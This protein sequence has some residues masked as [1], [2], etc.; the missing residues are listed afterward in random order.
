[1]GDKASVSSL[2]TPAK[3]D[4]SYITPTGPHFYISSEHISNY[5]E[6][7]KTRP[8]RE[9]FAGR[10]YNSILLPPCDEVWSSLKEKQPRC[11]SVIWH[12]HRINFYLL[13]PLSLLGI[14]IITSLVCSYHF[15]TSMPVYKD[16]FPLHIY[17]V[18]CTLVMWQS[19]VNLRCHSSGATTLFFCHSLLLAWIPPIKLGGMASE[20][21]VLSH[22]LHLPRADYRHYHH[23]WFFSWV[24]LI[25]FW[26]SPMYSKHFLNWNITSVF[27]CIHF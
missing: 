3:Q 16:R 6:L 27:P 11:S 7:W 5:S 26:L 8:S 18:L 2:T 14:P 23:I 20:S 25:K 17:V 15:L 24:P 19:V 12:C 13:L 9:L 1:M 10:G 22:L 21:Q 4:Q